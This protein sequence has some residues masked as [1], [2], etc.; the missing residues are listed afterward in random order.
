MPS[1]VYNVPGL[2]TRTVNVTHLP[3]NASFS[4]NVS[5]DALGLPFKPESPVM[6]FEEFYDRGS[7]LKC[8]RFL[9]VPH[10]NTDFNKNQIVSR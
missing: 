6:Y 1:N 10:A 4:L 5:R 3:R 8:L 9:S 2:L 7:R